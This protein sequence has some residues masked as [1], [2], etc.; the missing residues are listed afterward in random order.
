MR[1]QVCGQR[2]G[3][4]RCECE[5]VW[6]GPHAHGARDCVVQNNIFFG[7]K[8]WQADFHGWSTEQ[9]YW[10]KHMPTMVKG[11][12][13]VAGQPVW[14]QMRGMDLHP[15]QMALPSGLT[16][17]GNRFERNVVVSASAEVPVLSLL[18]V[19]FSHNTFDSNLYWAPGGVVR[20]GF[21]SAGAAV[22]GDLVGPWK[23]EED[24][25]PA[26]WKLI[27]KPAGSPVG[28]LKR[29]DSGMALQIS[30]EGAGGDTK[31]GPQY[32]G[33]GVEL[34]PGATYRLRA[35]L[36][37][38][39]P[40]KAEFAVQSFVANAYFWMS[41][42]SAVQ[43]GSEWKE[44]EVIFEVPSPGKPG[45]NEQMKKFSP[46]LGWRCDNGTLEVADLALHRVTPRTEFEALRAQGAD[47]RSVV[48][49]PVWEDLGKFELGKDSPA[50]S[51]GFQRI[52]FERIGPQPE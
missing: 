26:G 18:R 40:G 16:M 1:M 21:Q 19:P 8:D 24:A 5:R 14:Q 7:S 17:R 49:D 2:G 34:E 29:V 46:R 3:G 41:P 39:V 38:S 22:G 13:S 51:L 33:P 35:R 42:R 9:T 6:G 15:T 12:E 25:L 47:A 43:V 32:A 48:A 11:F 23:G 30:C 50:W 44:Q 31:V 10:E 36:R 52:P 20:T 27:S 37:A 28:R 4:G 45:W